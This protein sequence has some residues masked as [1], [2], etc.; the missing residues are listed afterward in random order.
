MAEFNNQLLSRLV[1]TLDRIDSHLSGDTMGAPPSRFSET[2][3]LP[4]NSSPK[5][6]EGDAEAFVD[7]LNKGKEAIENI[8]K[9]FD[10]FG[11]TI[12]KQIP[13][14][15][16]FMRTHHDESAKFH[17]AMQGYS[18]AAKEAADSTRKYIK[19]NK[20]NEE[21]LKQHARSL[22]DVQQAVK[23]FADTVKNKDKVIKEAEDRRVRL[24]GERYQINRAL[25]RKQIQDD[26]DARKELEEKRSKINDELEKLSEK[27][28]NVEIGDIEGQKTTL[29]RAVDTLKD[30]RLK[31]KLESII[32]AIEESSDS[33]VVEAIEGLEDTVKGSSIGQ[34][35]EIN[36]QIVSAE[37]RHQEM[38]QNLQALGR[39]IVAGT[40]EAVRRTGRNILLPQRLAMEGLGVPGRAVAAGRGVSP[41]EMYGFEEEFRYTLTRMGQDMGLGDSREAIMAGE[42]GDMLT[43]VRHRFNLI[44]EE[45]H[46]MLLS[47]AEA[48]RLGGLQ[49]TEQNAEAAMS[50]IR[51]FQRM[52]MTLEDATKEVHSMLADPFLR[53]TL[54]DQSMEAL[55]EEIERRM[56]LT[57]AL[58]QQYDIV[59]QIIDQDRRRI[60][61]DTGTLIRETIMADITAAEVGISPDDRDILRRGMMGLIDEDDPDYQRVRMQQ[62]AAVGQ[63]YRDALR[64]ED[65]G[66]VAML[67]QF[68]EGMGLDLQ[69]ADVIH[70][71]TQQILEEF[72]VRNIAELTD[73]QLEKLRER[74]AE[75]L[76]VPD[77]YDQASTAVRGFTQALEIAAGTLKSEFGG[78][79]GGIAGTLGNMAETALSIGAYEYAKRRLFGGGG[80][81][82]GA[83][84]GGAGRF[85]ASRGAGMLAGGLALGKG[86]LVGGSG[87][88]G[89][90]AGTLMDRAWEE[91]APESRRTFS[92]TLGTGIDVLRGDADRLRL[93]KEMGE[94]PIAPFR[95]ARD[96]VLWG[97]DRR[98]A[99]F[100]RDE[101]DEAQK[102]RYKEEIRQ[103]L[104]ATDFSEKQ[105]YH[106]DSELYREFFDYRH[107]RQGDIF[108]ELQQSVPEDRR[109]AM[110][111]A[112][113][114]QANMRAQ[115][116]ALKEFY[117]DINEIMGEG[118]IKFDEITQTVKVDVEEETSRLRD[119]WDNFT[120]I[121]SRTDEDLL[122]MDNIQLDQ[123]TKIVD[124]SKIDRID[125]PEKLQEMINVVKSSDEID[126]AIL[127][128]LKDRLSALINVG[129]KEVELQEE[130]NRYSKILNQ[131]NQ[132]KSITDSSIND[133]I[134][135]EN[136]A[137]AERLDDFSNAMAGMT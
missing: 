33:D 79:V 71:R 63:Q 32:D 30:E 14:L 60:F 107:D 10:S 37:R 81:A 70:A 53:R 18:D 7:T 54:E 23:E 87:A 113:R 66:R 77:E 98:Q 69:E 108:D 5:T 80:R 97:D 46:R 50:Q 126:E 42:F 121:F 2:N 36:R 43:T 136:K 110:A 1:H 47:T 52:G 11:V 106:K 101:P 29:R 6:R 21:K 25:R 127:E 35:F 9:H 48:L 96:A 131:M 20:N 31:E 120:G 84:R 39:A 129:E 56:V 41:S 51:L 82:G 73:E 22:D 104:R 34:K 3:I 26:E 49:V 24:E 111:N 91:H 135:A 100:G 28:A 125:D 115:A 57:R 67:R 72:G 83:A 8:N 74:A 86:L 15:R 13:V 134:E 109:Q 78:L 128:V 137:A 64:D 95:W 65:L 16:Q 62:M 12:R 55:S 130:S 75:D 59:K 89:Y 27:I 44:G 123:I 133:V 76:V 114:S 68:A 117:E 17:R 88:A 119:I 112:H 103:T 122:G 40:A 58:N 118:T 102:Q 38:Q 85:I 94:D 92:T 45:A 116:E 132:A 105:L 99:I 4:N 93:M 61:G 19:E 90:G 124:S